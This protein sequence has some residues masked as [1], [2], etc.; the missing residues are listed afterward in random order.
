MRRSSLLWSAL[1]LTTLML[2]SGD[3]PAGGGNAAGP[4]GDWMSR[5]WQG[6]V[7][8]EYRFSPASGGAYSA[9]NRAQGLRVR[10]E[11]G[12]VQV[13]PRADERRSWALGLRLRGI[14]REGEM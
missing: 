8:S 6:I 11:G 4:T 12:G 10:T 2:A 9:P 7:S 5:A 14:G 13:T 1:I 3:A